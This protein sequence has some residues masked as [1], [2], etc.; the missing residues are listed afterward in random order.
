[1]RD[2]CARGPVIPVLTVD[3]PAHAEPLARALVAGGLRVIEVTLR[4]AAAL[5][6]IETI[7]RHVP[8]SIV[9][10]GSLRTPGDVSRA[11]AAGARF[12]VSPGLTPALLARAQE[13]DMP[14]LPG[15]ATP[16][17]A[18][19]AAERGYRLLKFF[20]AESCGGTAALSAWA[21]P[22]AGL[23]FCPTGGIGPDNASDYL[24]LANVACIGGS[25][26]A[27]PA[28]IRA[29]D[30]SGIRKSAAAAAALGVP[31]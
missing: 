23:E 27:P 7:A 6:A 17:E 26:V 31:R 15:V 13:L 4:T 30:W 25:W 3:D 29:G 16:S 21:G 9:G 19:A 12:G 1:M 22:L 18:M 24:R 8:D 10:A 5:E 14:F 11:A 20:P 2:I 28:R